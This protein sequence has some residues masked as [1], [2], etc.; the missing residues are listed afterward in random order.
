MSDG[1][2]IQWTDATWNPVTGCSPVGP[3][4][5]NCYAEIFALRLRA[6]RR[7]KYARGFR[8][9]LHPES[10]EEPDRW[11]RPRRVFVCSMGDLFHEAIPLS[12]IRRVFATMERNDQHVYQILTKRAER[13]AELAGELS[14]T[15]NLWVGVSVE[16]DQHL[17]RL[18]SLAEV[19]AAIRFVSL[20]PLIGPVPSLLNG[21]DGLEDPLSILDW[22]IVGG[23][24]GPKAR[25]MP[26]GWPARIRDA[27]VGRGIP[28]FFKQ[29]SEFDRPRDRLLD[30]RVW[31]EFPSAWRGEGGPDESTL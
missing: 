28:F 18:I 23:E 17:Y 9:T 12:F 10:L 5:T 6:M 27:A 30:G 2:R 16:D 21:L 29:H 24:S 8:P 3:G 22:I 7:S 19:P 31:N 20:E 15:P 26:D 14:W 13:L 1:S 4:C 11:R 25:P